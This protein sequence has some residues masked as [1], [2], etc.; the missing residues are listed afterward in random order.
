MCCT[1]L[2]VFYFDSGLK[3]LESQNFYL[4][5]QILSIVLKHEFFYF[6]A[7]ALFPL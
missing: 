5:I 7:P 1:H 6:I 2:A 3:P 4:Q